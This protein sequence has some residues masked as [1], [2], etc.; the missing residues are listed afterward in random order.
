MKTLTPIRLGAPLLVLALQ[1]CIDSP[2]RLVEVI[3]PDPDA[4]PYLP[5]ATTEY[6]GGN[7]L[8]EELSLTLT[9][10]DMGYRIVLDASS[11]RSAGSERNGTL[12]KL[13]DCVY[14]SDEA[15]AVF[16]LAPNGV[17]TGGVATPDSTG[18]APMVAFRD[19]FENSADPTAFNAIADINVIIGVD[20]VGGVA[21]PYGGS[22]RIRNAGTFQRCQDDATSRFSVY[23]SGCALTDKGY[24][25]YNADRNAF[26]VY[27][28]DPAGSAVTEGGTLNGSMVIGLVAGAQVPVQL[29][30]E[31]ANRTGL[32]LHLPQ[33]PVVAEGLDGRYALADTGSG[34]ALA[35]IAGTAF[36]LDTESATLTYDDPVS[37]VLAA[38]GTVNGN[39]LA[40]RGL[41]A[42]VPAAGDSTGPALALG[43]VVP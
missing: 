9:P 14:A 5:V 19:T 2:D 16:A 1:A 12:T 37:G 18:F 39:L 31:S 23:A 35:T 26:D 40:G 30:R 13:E 20:N 15:G 11:V 38:T 43:V 32:Y 10:D 8:G 21:T 41:L 27:A 34:N 29:L 42:R 25:T 33:D 7:T 22:G 24:L 6:K 4:C 36:T 3:N 28:T 17:V